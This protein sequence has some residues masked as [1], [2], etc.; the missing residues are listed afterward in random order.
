MTISF[1][2]TIFLIVFH[3]LIDFGGQT[4]RRLRKSNLLQFD[5]NPI[6][7]K[8]KQIAIKLSALKKEFLELYFY[9]TPIIPT[10]ARMPLS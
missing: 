4:K 7:S 9:S 8:K 1:N 3:S 10:L 6:V 2:Y 5:D